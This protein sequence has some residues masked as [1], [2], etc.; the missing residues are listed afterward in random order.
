ML[1]SISNAEGFAIVQLEAMAYGK[2]VINTR[3]VSGVPEVCP[4]GIAGITVT[5]GDEKELFEAMRT[6]GEG[7]S[8]R[9]QY[10]IN[11]I[12]LIRQKYTTSVL[13]NNYK[14]LFD[15][16]IEDEDSI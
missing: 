11:C 6:L 13:V 5:P 4:D 15:E 16:L 3:L 10:G 8:L 7:E 14:R 12:N 2:P 9:R 1:P